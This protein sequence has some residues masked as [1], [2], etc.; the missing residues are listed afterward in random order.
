[1]RKRLVG[2]KK[3]RY[4]ALLCLAVIGSYAA[5]GDKGLLDVYRLKRER[6]TIL[7]HNASL[8]EENRRLERENSLLKT[9]RRYIARIARKELG[10]IGRNEV[11]YRFEDRK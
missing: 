3:K 8:E 4:A 1:M 7:A 5:F 11:V 6:N 2:L 10:L 9:D